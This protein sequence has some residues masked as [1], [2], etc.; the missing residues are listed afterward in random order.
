MIA[1]SAAG[2]AIG[3]REASFYLNN[4][5]WIRGLKLA[6]GPGKTVFITASKVTVSC[7][8]LPYLDLA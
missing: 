7:F 3:T 6:D 8:D 5:R 1:T 4:P 2:R